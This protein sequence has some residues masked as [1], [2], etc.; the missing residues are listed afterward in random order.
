MIYIGY[1]CFLT[2]RATPIIASQI[3]KLYRSG[4]YDAAEKIFVSICGQEPFRKLIREK[5]FAAP[6]FKIIYDFSQNEFEFPMLNYLHKLAPSLGHD[7]I[8]Y[9]HSKGVSWPYRECIEQWRDLLDYFAIERYQDAIKKLDEGHTTCGV[10][11]HVDHYSG[12]YWWARPAYLT[13]LPR[14]QFEN[15]LEFR[16]SLEHWIGKSSARLPYCQ[17]ESVVNHYVDLFP[18]DRYQK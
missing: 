1:H 2:D 6:K 5:F 3:E 13:T 10:N 17:F 11:W 14:L 4:L 7:C 15:T 12:N 18:K 16:Q 8:L 9:F